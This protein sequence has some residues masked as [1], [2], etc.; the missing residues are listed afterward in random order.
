VEEIFEFENFMKNG[1]VI[2]SDDSSGESDE[3]NEHSEDGILEEEK[4]QQLK[5]DMIDLIDEEDINL[6]TNERMLN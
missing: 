4:E 1:K 6:V 3:N 5:S 2:K